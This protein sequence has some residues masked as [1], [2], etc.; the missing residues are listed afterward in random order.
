MKTFSFDADTQ[1]MGF[2]GFKDTTKIYGLGV[3][4]YD[5]KCDPQSGPPPPPEPEVI[6]KTETKI[7]T[8]IEYVDRVETV[9]EEKIVEVPVEVEVERIVIEKELSDA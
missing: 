1:I 9:V 7:E 8:K 4:N 5:T 6:I 2:W 3:I